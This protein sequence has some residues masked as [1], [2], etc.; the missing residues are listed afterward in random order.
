[1]GK[2][3]NM[4]CPVIKKDIILILRSRPALLTVFSLLL[5]EAVIILYS[6][7]IIIEENGSDISRQFKFMQNYVLIF[8]FP[9]VLVNILNLSFSLSKE[10]GSFLLANLIPLGE[11]TFLRSKVY[12]TFVLSFL[13]T[14][15]FLYAGII[16]CGLESFQNLSFLTAT[17]FYLLFFSISLCSFMVFYAVCFFDGD[18]GYEPGVK[19]IIGMMFFV[20]AFVLASFM[21]YSTALSHYYAYAT[22]FRHDYPNMEI[23]IMIGTGFIFLILTR[24]L[25]KIAESKLIRE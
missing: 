9:L 16:F 19:G 4:K 13:L 7:G 12:S 5:I 24:L 22:G 10:K 25:L 1:M 6:R 20:S 17:T 2:L 14:F 21:I 18:S 3:N 11:S 15:P 8:Y 23:N